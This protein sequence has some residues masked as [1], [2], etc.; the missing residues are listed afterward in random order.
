VTIKLFR[1]LLDK[2]GRRRSADTNCRVSLLARVRAERGSP[3]W[4][5]RRGLLAGVLSLLAVAIAIAVQAQDT[6]PL[7]ERKSLPPRVVGAQRFLAQRGWKPHAA[8]AEPRM[9]GSILS[10][11]PQTAT[12]EGAGST[13]TWQPLGPSAV[14]TP[15]YGLVTGRVSSIAFDPSD[16]TGNRVYLGTTGGGVWLSQNAGTSNTANVVFAPLTDTLGAMS[17]AYD[18]SI[19]VGALT[20]QPGG[21]GVILA[22]TGDPND[23]LDSYYGAGILRS[24]DGGNT[25]SLIV[26]TADHEWGFAGEGFAGFAWS[27]VN[28]QVV[29]AAVSQAYEG[30]LTDAVRANVSYEGLYYSNDSG[31]TWSL[32][33][34][35]D[36]NGSDVQGPTDPF[37]HPDGN[38]ATSVV[39]NPVR[40]LFVAAV[41]FH[42]YYQSP[43]GVTWTRLSA[44]PGTSLTTG[45]CPTNSR[46]IGSLGCPIFRGTLAVNP[47]TGDTFAWTVDIDN[48]DQGI[49][50]DQCSDSG[51]VCS[52]HNI[53][54]SQQ[55]NT[56][57]LE[58]DGPNQG[59]ITIEN[60][61]YNLALAAVPSGQDTLL[62][63]GANDLWKCS[64]AMSC[65]WRNTTNANTCMSAQVAGYQHALAWSA[66]TPLEIFLGNDSGLWRSMDA[67]GETGSVCNASDASHFQNLN[68][69]LGS[70]AEVESMS[71]VGTSP[72]TMM[73]GL[74]VNG[75]AGV[76]STTG[77]TS[78]WPQILGG[79]GGPVAIDPTNNSNWYVNNDAGVSIHLCAQTDDCTP[80]DFGTVALVTDADVGGDGNTMTTPAAFLVDPLDASQLLI[81][82]C[83]VW[84]GPA[85][86]SGW[87]GANAISPFLDG[88]EGNGA[89]N[90][91]ALVRSMDVMVLASGG[92]MIY[93]GMYG[94][95][96]GGAT[97]AGHV[98]SAILNPNAGGT[99]V[100]QDLTLNPVTNDTAGMNF[101]GFDISSITI[102]SHDST[103]NTV[104]V[105]VE[106]IPEP[107]ANV[108]VVYRSTDGGAH[109]QTLESNLPLSPANS[110]AV[111]PQDP[112][113]VY[114]ATDSGV[115]STRQIG[116]CLTGTGNCWSAY[117]TG[118]PL[119]PVIQLSAAPSTASLNVL[120][121]A[122]YG[123]G[124]WQI[125][126]WTAGIQLTTAGASPTSL[127]FPTQAFGVASSAQTITVT[128]TGGIG[129]VVTA[130]TASGDFSETD[131]CQSGTEGAGASCTIQVVFTPTQVGSRTGQLTI[132]GNVAGGE[133]LVGLSGTG[134]NPPPVMLS[135]VSV[136]FG[137]VEVG[138]TS[139]SLQVTV[140]NAGSAAVPVSSLTINAP[141]VLS[142]NACG[143]SLAANSNCQLLL[144]FSPTQAGPVTGTLT[145]ADSAG[146][147]TVALSGNGAAPPTDTLSP[148]S[149]TFPGTIVG[150]TSAQQTVSL[151]NSG[152]MPLNSIALAA[153]RPFQLS[154]NCTTQLAGNS[155]CSTGVVF[156]PTAQGV[157]T[158]ILTISDLIRTQTV[159]LPGTGLQPPQISVSP[160]ALGYSTQ[161]LGVASSPIM[162]TINNTGGAPMANV[163]F[164]ITGLSAT[165]FST[166]VTTCGA[167]LNNGSSCTIQVV[168][169]PADAG[170][171][172]ATLTI[173]S[174]TLG[175]KAVQVPLTGTGYAPDGVDV[176]PAQMSFTVA[177]LG[178]SSDTQT[179]TITNSSSLAA[180]GLAL[181]VGAP[182]GL[183]QNNCGTNLAAAASC[184]VGVVYTPTTNGASAGA[185]TIASSVNAAT[186]ILNGI[187]GAAGSSQFQPSLSTFPTT[188]VGT[189]SGVQTVTVTNTGP[190]AFGDLVPSVSSSFQLT[191]TTCTSTLAIGAG[192]TAAVTFNPGTAGQQT[193]NLT[194]TSSALATGAQAG[195]LG[196]GFDF[197]VALSG[198][199]SQTVSN[200]QTASFTLV[201][202]TMGGS[203]GTF[204]FACGTLPANA[205]CTFNPA[206][207]TVTGNA[208]GNVAV[209]VT[210]GGSANSARNADSR[211]AGWGAAPAVAGLVLLPLAWRRRRKILMMVALF[212]IITGGISSCSGSGGG[213]G[214]SSTSGLG[215]ESAPGTY[216]IPVSVAS[217]GVVHQVTL[218]LT[219]D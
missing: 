201:L 119:A 99:P 113:T 198:P 179:V 208:P 106:G 97:A 140:Q 19:S 13:A 68:S 117:G 123:R 206:S 82:T 36:G 115:F 156:D 59:P 147:Q 177:A 137:Q 65:P 67:I 199:S 54:F 76:K 102:D 18:A 83:R 14:N 165:S 56:S 15:H 17:G 70:L 142:G 129:L 107:A 157:Q 77:P 185:L 41:R 80:A 33:R 166:G 163:G 81:G 55:W 134:A 28:Q 219:V 114:I 90:G 146:T 187:G 98:L 213:T 168:F 109:W 10:I 207:E 105:T 64:L 171:A 215:N 203:S 125:P 122:M 118:L 148:M 42:G 51:G 158:G 4:G 40:N 62:L 112:N 170:G 145:V 189:A 121:A 3:N 66:T 69:G 175:V 11:S 120:A 128:N 216:S 95:G 150:E 183:T 48:Q 144:E 135:P 200:G 108:R 26:A 78:E 172:A 133:I 31:A 176:S 192:C 155:S 7:Q 12:P 73:T 23:A 27:T 47:L 154:S 127:T 169:T 149:L 218:T 196:M 20:V 132:S 89:C 53:A 50:Q 139:S 21:T 44:Q 141:F 52:N 209:Q 178:Q 188:G 181:T 152:G 205:V 49:W 174:S 87:T 159:A 25:W 194:F 16:L 88:V 130:I 96:D 110:L 111:D 93:V 151:T 136:N 204:T 74:G 79:E 180:N 38:A 60:G 1:D 58:T 22:G 103:G 94:A 124:V 126:L 100:W 37:V 167:A 161:D 214:G 217:N 71:P 193:G 32:A 39:W 182:F 5:G 143:S 116:N 186:V 162:L 45:V 153:S 61:D 190:V 195:L 57:A 202:T 212:A 173:S 104:Y 211:I 91:D 8:R 131:N 34:I 210:T 86:G 30:A 2:A 6:T 101:F 43:D 164:Q 63:A 9:R 35:T 160:T 197:A 72:Y 24:T 191:S 84:R 75:T 92:E 184:S 138:S 85:N 46:S 29:V